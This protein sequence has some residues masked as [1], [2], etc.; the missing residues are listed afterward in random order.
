MLSGKVML[1]SAQQAPGP[2]FVLVNTTSRQVCIVG[3]IFQV[4]REQLP[5]PGLS[6][7]DES[8]GRL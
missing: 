8:E 6:E 7:E 1:H 4:R 2:V 5:M 3:T